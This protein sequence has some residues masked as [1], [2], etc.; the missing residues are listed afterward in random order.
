MNVLRDPEVVDLLREEP[1]L[2][3]LADA[4]AA[5]QTARS[6]RAM[7]ARRWRGAAAAA[8][9][10]AVVLAVLLVAPWNSSGAS[11]VDRAL[12]AVSGGPVV[13]AVVSY[14]APGTT[15]V[16]LATGAARPRVR[17]IEYWYD[18][19]PDLLR[20]RLLTDGV[21]VTEIVETPEHAWS[22]LG[23]FPTGGGFAPQL[24]PALAGFATG[25]RDALANGSAHVVGH[26]TVA[27]KDAIALRVDLGHGVSE[28]VDVDA[29]TYR[30]LRIVPDQGQ[31]L[32]VTTIETLPYDPSLFAHPA[33]SAPRGTGGAPGSTTPAQP[34]DV[35]SALGGHALWLGASY[36]R[37]AAVAS[38]QTGRVQLTDG[39]SVE[40]TT[41]TFA[42]GDVRVAEAATPAAAYLVGMN[43]GGDPT[44]PPGSIELSTPGGR[45]HGELVDAGL[46]VAI[47]APTTADVLAAA[48]ALTAVP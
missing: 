45:P 1:E 24:D 19:A 38:L 7:R 21:Q 29:A 11:I 2:L 17:S 12:A 3:A 46:W 48:R 31:T 41:G 16:D 15:V 42:Y 40:A 6:S 30:P 35:A 33:L 27:G 9:A 37:S 39:S 10:A 44:A 22:D 13:H 23:D 34:S 4:V 36:G 32:T 20:T 25:Y 26:T 28:I 43:D 18:A 14:D 47:D 5:T 8:L